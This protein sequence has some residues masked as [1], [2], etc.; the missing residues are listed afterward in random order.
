MF[1]PFKTVPCT[2]WNVTTAP[3]LLIIL[4]TLP[5]PHDGEFLIRRCCETSGYLIINVQDRVYKMHLVFFSFTQVS[6]PIKGRG[7]TRRRVA[8]LALSVVKLPTP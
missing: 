6:P 1:L 7:A 4:Y 2:E 8:H 5:L 3:P